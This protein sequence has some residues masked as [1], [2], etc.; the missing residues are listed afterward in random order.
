MVEAMYYKLENREG[1]SAMSNQP[2]LHNPTNSSP[3]NP[4]PVNPQPV[5]PKDETLVVEAL[6]KYYGSMPAVDALSFAVRRGEIFGLLGPNGAGKTTTIRM[7]MDIFKADSGTISVL[8]DPPGENSHRIGYLPEERGLYQEQRIREVL[9]F[10]AQLKGLTRKQA[11]RQ[12]TEWLKR[13]ELADRADDKVN[14]LSRGMQQKLQVAAAL[15]HSPALAILDEPFQGLDPVNVELV[16]RI[17]REEQANGTSIVLSA[18]QMNLVEELCDR[19]LL[20]N[21]GRRL[22]Y[23]TLQEIKRDYA[24]NIV[25]VRTPYPLTEAEL[26]PIANLEARQHD[27]LVT[28]QAQ[29]DAQALLHRLVEQG[30]EIQ[31]FEVADTPLDEIFVALVSQKE[32]TATASI[33]ETRQEERHG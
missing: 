18:H 29:N 11:Q 15:V 21:R 19:I 14:S 4:Q 30:V 1:Q 33:T 26:G 28:L 2:A 10:L 12:T 17:M 9:V 8:G 31:A 7:V 23:G 25:R 16:K 24:P 22:L 20:I 6:T 13:V 27:Y 32:P 3:V 5:N